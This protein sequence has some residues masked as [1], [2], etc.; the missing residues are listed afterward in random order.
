MTRKEL[1]KCGYIILDPA[2]TRQKIG[3]Y[4]IRPATAKPA[5]GDAN[6]IEL[7]DIGKI[8]EPFHCDYCEENRTLESK[9]FA[10]VPREIADIIDGKEKRLIIYRHKWRCSKCKKIAHPIN[11]PYTDIYEID[12]NEGK[13]KKLIKRNTSDEFDRNIIIKIMRNPGMKNN[14]FEKY[15]VS[16]GQV[17]KLITAFIEKNENALE[18]VYP[19]EQVFLY[20]FSYKEKNKENPEKHCCCVFGQIPAKDSAEAK[21]VLLYILD[22]DDVT[23]MNAF[24][25][26][27]LIEPNQAE[28]DEYLPE[29]IHCDWNRI[30]YDTLRKKYERPYIAILKLLVINALE[31]IEITVNNEIR[32]DTGALIKKLLKRIE[33]RDSRWPKKIR[34]IIGGWWT[35]TEEYIEQGIDEEDKKKR[36]MAQSVLVPI[37]EKLNCFVDGMYHVDSLIKCNNI[38]TCMDLIED[39]Q[40]RGTSYNI[41]RAKIMFSPYAM[42]DE[43][44]AEQS[45]RLVWCDSPHYT[46][47]K[48]YVDIEKLQEIYGEYC[49]D[50]DS[51]NVGMV[52]D[53]EFFTQEYIEEKLRHQINVEALLNP[54]DD[55]F[56]GDPYFLNQPP[57]GGFGVEHNK[58]TK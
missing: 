21:I 34:K 22:K 39:F 42:H 2:D 7:S 38:D 18:S 32:H 31:E 24:L 6:A 5:S 4:Q 11:D 47:Q 16:E 58:K 28:C 36:K 27:K 10:D 57:A 3:K 19:C 46:L 51:D 37:W 54:S 55:D 52:D 14:E 1:E 17:R 30:I 23:E 33:R 44:F 41:M 15:G 13:T 26:N 43:L 9:G 20:P 45:M 48:Y 50:L 25:D 8:G 53:E 12:E 35:D 56:G 29:V 40:S 49:T